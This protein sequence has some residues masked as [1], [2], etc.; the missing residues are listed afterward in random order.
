MKIPSFISAGHTPALTYAVR[1]LQEVYPF[2]P[3]P[4]PVATHLLLP[5]PSFDA[6]SYIR[7][8]GSIEHLLKKLPKD[9]T[10]VGGLLEHPA[11][12]E[13][14]TIDLL[15]DPFYIAENANITAHCAIRLAMQK[16]PCTLEH[17][18][19][20][21]IGWGRIGKCLCRLLQGLGT[22]I[23]IAVRKDTDLAMLTALGIRAVAVQQLDP[24]QYR[25]IFNTAP[26]MLLPQCPGNALKIDL[27]SNLGLGGLDVIWARGLPGK[28]APESSG[29]L[30]ADSIIR[31]LNKE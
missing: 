21:V 16:L 5:V 9:I 14:A 15:K 20:L 25:L 8:G 3:S 29:K 13:Y 26:A 23:T 31:I 18:P 1:I 19:V 27:A 28:D 2:S 6:D 22:D 4:T 17:C 7:G 30:I 12:A 10:V 24:T 11:L